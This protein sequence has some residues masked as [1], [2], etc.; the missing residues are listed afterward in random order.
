MKVERLLRKEVEFLPLE[1][2]RLLVPKITVTHT[3]Q[4]G[5]DLHYPHSLPL[6]LPLL[7]ARSEWGQV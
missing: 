5:A 7:T 1:I 4:A 3:G 6:Q 2:G